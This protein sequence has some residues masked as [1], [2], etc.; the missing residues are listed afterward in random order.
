M[1]NDS[2]QVFIVDDEQEIRDSLSKFFTFHG[3]KVSVYAD[4][5]S[6]LE[7]LNQEEVGCLV[8]DIDMDQMNGIELQAQLR[9]L[10]CIRPTIFITGHANVDVA[11]K[12]MKLGAVDFIEK[13]FDP[14]ILLAKVTTAIGLTAE[15]I[16]TLNRFRLLTKKET[17]VFYCAV[18]GDKNRRIA[19]QLFISLPTVEAHRSRVMKKMQA[20]S[21]AELVRASVLID[22]FGS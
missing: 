17:E 1:S 20:K 21:I 18:R 4:A 9:K 3:F 10:K 22:Q 6:Y 5:K 15:K 2:L 19:D 7:E 14:D 12:A 13:P 16:A 11:V 8:S